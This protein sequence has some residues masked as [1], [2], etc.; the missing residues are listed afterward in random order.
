MIGVFYSEMQEVSQTDF[1]RFS[2]STQAPSIK[3]HR[4]ARADLEEVI[5]YLVALPG[6]KIQAQCCHSSCQSPSLVAIV[7]LSDHQLPSLMD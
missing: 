4:S 1:F 5:L 7:Q 3:A 2:S 6:E